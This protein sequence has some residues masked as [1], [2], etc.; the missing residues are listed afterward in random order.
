MQLQRLTRR[1]PSARLLRPYPR[2]GD[3][4]CL[5]RFGDLARAEAARAHANVLASTADQDVN[6]LQIWPLQALGLDVGVTDSIGNLALLAANF[7]LRW[8]GFSGRGY[9]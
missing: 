8:H 9:H 1:A 3:A 4:P 5:D 2:R 7:T 6:P